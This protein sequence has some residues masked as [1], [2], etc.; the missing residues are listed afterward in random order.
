MSS[1]S[2]AGIVRHKASTRDTSTRRPGST[3]AVPRDATTGGPDRT[4]L[5]SP[6]RSRSAAHLPPREQRTAEASAG[7]ARSAAHIARDSAT[8]PHEQ[9][10]A[11]ASAERA[12][13]ASHLARGSATSPHE[14]QTADASAGRARTTAHI[15]RETAA[16]RHDGRAF[17]AIGERAKSIAHTPRDSAVRN[18]ETT[19]APVRA[20][21][22]S[23]PRLLRA[24]PPT[25]DASEPPPP[26][27]LQ[28]LRREIRLRHYSRRTEEAYTWW[29][30]RY[31]Q[32]NDYRHPEQLGVPA[33]RAFLTDLA[34]THNVSASTQNQARAAILFLYRDVLGS[35]LPFVEGVAP[36]KHS[37]RIPVV[38]SRAEVEQVVSR[39]QGVSR[40]ICLLMYGGGLRLREAVTLRLKDVDLERA[41]ITV[42]SG[43]GGKD[44]RT[45]LPR[46]LIPEL[47]EQIARVRRQ[48]A[49][50]LAKGGGCVELPTALGRKYPAAKRDIGWQWLFPATRT[51]FHRESGDH[52]RHHFHETAVQRAMRTAVL[53]S[54]VTKRA[55]C[56][57]LRHSFATHLLEAGYD[58]RTIQELLGHKDVA[59]TM[60]YTH[61]LNRGGKG[62]RSPADRL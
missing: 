4:S 49:S 46:N 42:R 17:K 22:E 52:R 62:V 8:S 29:I 28:R 11:E 51:Y 16:V 6:G 33:V 15:R 61:V 40:L 3:E 56:H 58:I 25:P 38:L 41:E 2:G 14:Q 7:R 23:L 21:G 54:G 20:V 44:R 53:A 50:D 57:T 39:L 13:S 34:T 60:I 26:K 35:P 36:A 47:Q 9:R 27:L 32:F 48:H 12:R 18:G 19:S 5:T 45:T 43:K 10:T 30:R 1:V 37:R 24:A 59:T 55:T 31:V